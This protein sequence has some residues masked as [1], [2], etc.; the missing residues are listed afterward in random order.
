MEEEVC[1]F[2]KSGFCKFKEGCKRKHFN[3]V[4]ENLSSCINIKE[5]QTRHP[6]ACKRFTSGI[7]CTFR[8]ECAYSHT[9][10]NPNGDE[11]IL[12]VKVEILEKTVIDLTNK[13]ETKNIEQLEKVVH[14]LTRKVLSLEH[15]IDMIK[16]NTETNNKVVKE[17]CLAKES[18]FNISDIKGSSS[19]PKKENRKKETSKGEL[20]NCKECSFK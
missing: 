4:C 18:S 9:R 7:E 19:T 2:H 6:K 13:I 11:N 1:K 20:L 8:E 3:K 16:S 5:C 15:E 12:K 14:A 10:S 17:K